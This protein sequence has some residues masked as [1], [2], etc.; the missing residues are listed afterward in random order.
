MKCATVLAVVVGAIWAAGT[1]VLFR[2][3]VEN[4]NLSITTQQVP[5]TGDLR[6][7]IVHVRP[8]NLGKVLGRPDTYRLRVKEIPVSGQAWKALQRSE[9]KEILSLNMLRHYPEG[10]EIEPGVEYDDIE[11]IV[12]KKGA[13]LLVS[14]ELGF[15][16]PDNDD[17][18]IDVHEVVRIE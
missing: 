12:V 3:Q 14:A 18:N 10:Y 8:K 5:Y 6:L 13:T 17:D 16:Y 1:F 15:E 4:L 9:L 11:I 2:S 7:L